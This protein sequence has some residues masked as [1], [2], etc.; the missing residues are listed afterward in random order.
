VF[1]TPCPTGLRVQALMCGGFARKIDAYLKNG[2]DIGKSNTPRFAQNLQFHD[3]LS[4]TERDIV[5]IAKFDDTWR[6]Q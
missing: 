5:K 3:S 4:M 6:P 2:G 1:A